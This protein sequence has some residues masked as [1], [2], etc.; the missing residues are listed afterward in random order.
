V[1]TQEQQSSLDNLFPADQAFTDPASIIAYQGDAG[2][3]RGLPDAVVIPTSTQQVRQAVAWAAQQRI[4]L[5]ARGAGT[6]LTGGSVAEKGGMVLSFS[7]MNN[8]LSIDPPGRQV[9]VQPGVVTEA[10]QRSLALYNLVY[11]PDPASLSVCTLGGNI[12]ENAGGPHCLKYG[13]TANYVAGL[14]VVL[15]NG[16]AISLGGRALDPPEYNFAGLVTGSEGTLAVVTGAILRL[17]RPAEAVKTLTATFP[18]VEQAG[19]AVS[20]IIAHRILPA[21]IELMDSGMLEIVEAYLQ[22]G[23]PTGAGALLLFELDGYAAGLKAQAKEICD[24][25]ELF[26]PLEIVVARSQAERELLWRGRRSAGG[27]ISRISP[28]EYLLDITLPRSRLAE[29]MAAINEIGAAH[30]F[31]VAFL[32]HA[33]DGNLH[34][35]LLCNLAIPGELNRVQ[36]A[37]GEILAVC[38]RLGGSIGGEHGIGIEK[39]THLPAMYAPGELAAM[40]EVKRVFDPQGLLNPGKIFPPDFQPPAQPDSPLAPLP[41]EQL[42]PANPQEAAASLRALQAAGQPV[43]LAGGGTHWQ[44]APD[45]PVDSSPATVLSTSGLRGITSLSTDDFYVSVL[46]GT[47]FHELQA[48]LAGQGFWVPLASSAP[49]TTIGGL[50]ACS[51][52]SP[53]RLLYGGLSEQV[54]ACQVALP[55]GRLLSFGRPLVKDIAGYAMS[56][57]FVGSYGTLGLLTEVSFRIWPLPAERRSLVTN[58]PDL[59]QAI[60]LAGCALEKAVICSG[61]TITRQTGQHTLVYTAEGHPVEVQAELANIRTALREG[62]ATTVNESDAHTATEAWTRQVAENMATARIGLPAGRLLDLALASKLPQGNPPLVIDVA[63]GLL[64]VPLPASHPQV[65]GQV[66]AGLRFTAEGLGGYAVLHCGPRAWLARP[67]GAET[68]DAWGTPRPATALMQK[69]KST[70]DPA[71]ILNPGEFPALN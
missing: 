30:G 24:L 66:L 5:I 2:L 63:A 33:G 47:P 31:R 27:A 44:G 59:E 8:I 70:W 10:L 17:R 46:A 69:M 25:L 14:E 56:K 7:R 3:D 61:I 35:S 13:V 18:S 9:S 4:P 51:A 23:F 65:A 41:G 43:Y 32:G 60:R 53:L 42:A 37:G 62:G 57:L 50:V 11:P 54:L 38:A 26:Q 21:T 68:F 64:A 55:D 67:A 28:N 1:L 36:T 71:G 22:A 48:E 12:A 45:M 6:G 40:L 19:Q 39:R 16:E 49:A 34:P 15:A 20:A 58:L 52:N 29:G